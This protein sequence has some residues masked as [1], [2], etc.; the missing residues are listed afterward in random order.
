MRIEPAT[1]DDVEVL[2]DLWVA[3]ASEQREFGSH[4][5]TEGNREAIRAVFSHQ[6]VD[7]LVLIASDDG[8]VGFV[9][10]A[11]EEGYFEQSATRG[12]IQNIYVVPQARNAGVG[13]AL[14]EAAEAALADRGADV[15]ALESMAGN[16]AARRFYERRGYTEHRIEVEKRLKSDTNV[17]EGD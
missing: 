10:F 12:V 17:K 11:I 4:L 5:E 9:N 15:V 2:T 16:E 3:L 6:V 13:T 1:L 8:I 14:L 7:D